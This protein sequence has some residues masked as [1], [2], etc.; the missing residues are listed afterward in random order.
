MKNK[1]NNTMK[2]RLI[3]KNV[4]YIIFVIL[5]SENLLAQ[6]GAALYKPCGACHT[7]GKGKSV[8]PD[9]KG[10]SKRR[11]NEWL[12][13]FIKS[14]LEMQKSGDAQAVAIFKEYN[15]VP[16]PPNQ[17][18]PDQINK[19][20]VYIDGSGANAIDPAK[21]AL[22]KFIDSML[23]KNSSLDIEKGKAFFTGK[24]LFR[25]GG[26]SC[27]VCHN[28][29]YDVSFGGGNLARD[30]T[31]AYSRLNGFAGIKG[32]LEIPPFASMADSYKNSPLT[33]LE[34]AY[35]QLY[36]KST[37][38]KYG[39]NPLIEKLWLLRNGVMG[40]VI[41][42]FLIALIWYKRKRK[43]VNNDILQRQIRYSK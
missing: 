8:G 20:L 21:E 10:I 15:N 19:I 13:K 1:L 29:G 5:L 3:L 34:I 23:K 33:E 30:L 27:I 12:L 38:S 4:I 22:M 14:P 24:K 40:G 2:I 37:N 7:I 25:N 35:L 17:L 36:L 28:A 9:L 6:D 16:M 18:T 43:S 32:V 42:T 11:T 39:K 41:I 31:R 26:P